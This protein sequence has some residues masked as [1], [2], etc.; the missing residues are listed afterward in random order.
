MTSSAARRA[1]R[2]RVPEPSHVRPVATSSSM[3][4]KD[5]AAW[6]DQLDAGGGWQPR[7]PLTTMV[8][9]VAAAPPLGT[10]GSGRPPL[11]GGIDLRRRRR[12]QRG[13]WGRLAPTDVGARGIACVESEDPSLR[14]I[15]SLSAAFRSSPS[16]RPS[17]LSSNA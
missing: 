10:A 5:R 11:G 14:A 2:H 16:T 8:C 6:S 17:A 4:A 1:Y 13:R 9:R 3:E 15:M 12:H 7:C